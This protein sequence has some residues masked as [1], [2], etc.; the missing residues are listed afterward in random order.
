[1]LLSKMLSFQKEEKDA[2][3]VYRWYLLSHSLNKHLGRR[4]KN[5][6]LSWKQVE[7]MAW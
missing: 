6:N 5:S 1:M 7:Y 4:K 3:K 2:Q